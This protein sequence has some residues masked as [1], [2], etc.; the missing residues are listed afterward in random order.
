MKK[1]KVIKPRDTVPMLD[2]PWPWPS[3]LQA[4]SR[5][6][7]QLGGTFFIFIQFLYVICY[8]SV[9]LYLLYIQIVQVYSITSIKL[10]FWITF[11]T[12]V[13]CHKKCF[14]V[15]HGVWLRIMTSRSQTLRC[16]SHRGVFLYFVFQ[17]PRWM[18]PWSQSPRF[19]SHCGIS[20]NIQQNR[21]QIRKCLDFLSGDQ[22]CSNLET[23]LV[24]HSI[25]WL[26]RKH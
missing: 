19:H 5:L 23:H 3:R 24:T 8:K 11:L 12:W 20:K 1:T 17:N 21:I 22:M 13:D 2:Q 14:Q 4:L 16:H 6:K 18:T 10:V 15:Q 25:W 26:N 9:Q 7:Y